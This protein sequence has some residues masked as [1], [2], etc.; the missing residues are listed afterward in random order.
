MERMRARTSIETEILERAID[1]IEESGEAGVKTH[2][3]AAECGVTAPVLYRLFTNREGLIIAAQAERYRRTFSS[4]LVDVE[5]EI[6]HRIARCLS[7]QDV[8]DAMKWF[9]EA[10]MTPERHHQRLVRLAV[11]GSAV[12]RPELMREVAKKDQEIV[13]QFTRI[14]EVAAEHG[15]INSSIELNA[16]VALWFGVIL[17]R[18]LPEISDGYINGEEW[19]KAAT[20][21]MLHLLFGDYGKL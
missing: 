19:N 12:S 21:S 6:A 8:I 1:A 7:R 14:F 18:Y 11:V 5:S 16:M 4:G 15:W 10:T 13:S 2:K 20:E 9:F 17:G 3:I